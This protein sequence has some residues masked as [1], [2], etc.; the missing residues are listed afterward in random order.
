MSDFPPLTAKQELF[1]LLCVELGNSTEAYRQ[2]YNVSPDSKPEGVWVEA[3]K[4]YRHPIVSLR[5]KEIRDDLAERHEVT[6]DSLLRELEEARKAA[7]AAEKPQASAAVAATMGKA[8]ITGKD[9]QVIE[10]LTAGAPI[11]QINRPERGS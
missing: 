6:I 9:K 3:S 10:H 8:R 2:A 11:I 5:I 7:L 4:L 1:A